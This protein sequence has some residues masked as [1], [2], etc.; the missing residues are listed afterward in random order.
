MITTELKT[1]E[2]RHIS[3]AINRPPHDV[4]SFVRGRIPR[5]N[6]G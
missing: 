3:V 1:Y 5:W 6:G 2:V 4:Y